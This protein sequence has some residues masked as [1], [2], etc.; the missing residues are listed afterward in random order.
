[1]SGGD[2]DLLAGFVIARR[3]GLPGR[4][5]HAADLAPGFI[6]AALGNRGLDA[7]QTLLERLLLREPG[8]EQGELAIHIGGTTSREPGTRGA[9][10]EFDAVGAG[11]LGCQTL[12][13]GGGSGMIACARQLFG[14]ID[15][16]WT[17][18][19]GGRGTAREHE[20]RGNDGPECE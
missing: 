2:G 17:A 16:R 3:T 1:M 4:R 10:A 8:W 20:S 18:A 15:V 6:A 7:Q 19:L 13:D 14:A 12:V 11:G 5:L 9:Q